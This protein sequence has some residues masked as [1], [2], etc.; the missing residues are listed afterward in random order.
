MAAILANQHLDAG[1]VSTDI[2]GPKQFYGD[3]MGFPSAGSVDI[4]NVGKVTRFQVGNSVL[5]VLVPL[6]KPAK[7]QREDGFSSTVGIRY[8]ALKV[9]NLSE[10]VV[11]IKEAGFAVPVPIRVLRPGVQVALVEDADGNTVELMEESAK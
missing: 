7:A 9:S 5:R 1:L 2:E 3:V 11:R 4:P 8:I 10:I 6:K